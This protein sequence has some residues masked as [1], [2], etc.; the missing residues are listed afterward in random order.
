M[1]LHANENNNHEDYAR[2]IFD[3][4]TEEDS[5]FEGG[6]QVTRYGEDA[7]IYK[8]ATPNVHIYSM[9]PTLKQIDGSCL[10][11]FKSLKIRDCMITFSHDQ[12]INI[13]LQGMNTDISLRMRRFIV[14]IQNEMVCIQFPNNR[15]FISIDEV[16][17]LCELIDSFGLDYISALQRIEKMLGISSFEKSKYWSKGYRLMKVDSNLWNSLVRFSNEFDY[18][19]GNTNWH[20]FNRNNMFIQVHTEEQHLR[21]IHFHLRL[22]AERCDDNFIPFVQSHSKVWIVWDIGHFENDPDLIHRDGYWDAVTVF[23]WLSKEFIPYATAYY[24]YKFVKRSKWSLKKPSFE[25]YKNSLNKVHLFY[26]S[27][28]QMNNDHITEVNELIQMLKSLESYLSIPNSFFLIDSEIAQIYDSISLC[29]KRIPLREYSYEY[30]SKE[31]G[32]EHS[33]DREEIIMFIN[34]CKHKNKKLSNRSMQLLFVCILEGLEQDF[35]KYL[36]RLDMQKIA[37]DI[38]P[39]KEKI[40]IQMLFDRWRSK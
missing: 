12:I 15:F 36:T 22:L 16:K 21:K 10:I 19:N 6:K 40:E 27:S 34:Q 11:T 14:G 9:M 33:K 1:L 31:I 32:C 30:I 25:D 18:Q 29:L 7:F 37:E 28:L 35:G 4:I 26:P 13:L 20:V 23:E 3:L 38:K 39:V 5:Y 8:D 17:Q 2:Q 24:N